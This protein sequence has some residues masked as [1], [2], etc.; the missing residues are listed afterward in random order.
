MKK[1]NS[2]YT[3]ELMEAVEPFLQYYQQFPIGFAETDR[4]NN[5]E[6]CKKICQ[7]LL[8]SFQN[9]DTHE[10]RTIIKREIE[11]FNDGKNAGPYGRYM[12]RLLYLNTNPN[13]V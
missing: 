8:T 1:T 3:Q 12:A 4:L 13:L 6:E 9:C 5:I 11:R 7:E 10:K 2:D